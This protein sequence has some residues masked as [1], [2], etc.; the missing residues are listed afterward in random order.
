MRVL[1]SWEHRDTGRV[2]GIGEEVRALPQH[3]PIPPKKDLE[4]GPRAPTGGRLGGRQVPPGGRGQVQSVEVGEEEPG[5]RVLSKGETLGMHLRPAN[6]A[7]PRGSWTSP[8][9]RAGDALGALEVAPNVQPLSAT[10]YRTSIHRALWVPALWGPNASLGLGGRRFPG[11]E[12]PMGTDGHVLDS[13]CSSWEAPRWESSLHGPCTV[14]T[15]P[16]LLPSPSGPQDSG[17][18]TWTGP[19]VYPLFLPE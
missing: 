3:P 6:P 2:H 11:P 7:P 1:V 16:S 14:S 19:P 9:E 4:R 17:L 10:H 5:R 8:G 15:F 12:C 13:S 18:R